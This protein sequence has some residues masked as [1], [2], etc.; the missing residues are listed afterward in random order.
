MDGNFR[1]TDFVEKQGRLLQ[2]LELFN[3]D[4]GVLE[5]FDILHWIV[6]MIALRNKEEE[7]FLLCSRDLI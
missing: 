7:E 6:E 3:L 4:Y 5:D 2:L 1:E